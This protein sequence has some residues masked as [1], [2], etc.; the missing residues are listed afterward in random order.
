MEIK[1]LTKKQRILILS[2]VLPVL[3]GAFYFVNKQDLD[4][5]YTAQD[6]ESKIQ[7]QDRFSTGDNSRYVEITGQVTSPGVY[8]VS[9]QLMVIEL[10]EL[11]GGLT[12]FAD[13]EVV[14]K[15]ISLSGIIEDRQKIYIPALPEFKNN[16]SN[17]LKSVGGENGAKI[18]I[19]TATQE[20]LDALPDIGPST[21]GKIISARPFK[22]VEDLKDVE[23]IGEKTYNNLISV[24]TL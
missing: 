7:E 1:N 24:I 11:A 16:S 21:A 19:N 2:I 8:E 18:N 3:V 9:R 14:H 17:S 10:I 5:E 20:Q 22:A 12:E 4:Y 13:L 15:D 23:G 6:N